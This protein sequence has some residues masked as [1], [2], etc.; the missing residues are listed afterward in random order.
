MLKALELIGF[1][2]FADK[3]RF[4]FPDGITVVVGPNGS[5]KSN[6]VDALKWV[7]GEQSAKSLRGKDMADVIFKGTGT[8]GRKPANTAEATVVFD[9]S[10]ATFPVD[11]DGSPRHPPRVSQRRRRVPDQRQALPA[12]DIRDMFRGTGV[13]VD[14]YSL[15]EQGK[16]DSCCRPTP[17]TAGRSSKKRRAS[18][19][20]RPRRSKPNAAGTRRPELLRLS[21]I[22]ERSKAGCAACGPR[23]PRPSGIASTASGCS[24]CGPL[25]ERVREIVGELEHAE[26]EHAEIAERRAEADAAVRA[27]EAELRGAGEQSRSLRDE[28]RQSVRA[29]A[30][31]AKSVRE[32]ENRLAAATISAEQ[33]GRQVDALE[34]ALAKQIERAEQS[35]REEEQK[36]EEARQAE[37]LAAAAQEAVDQTQRELAACR[38]ELSELENRRSGAR[39]RAS[40]LEE[41]EHRQEGISAGAQEVLARARQEPEGPFGDVCGLVADLIEVSAPSAPLIDVALGES[42]QYVVVKGE[43]FIEY[44]AEHRPA[45]TGRLGVLP[46]PA[47]SEATS[48]SPLDLDG[49]PGVIGRADRMIDTAPWFLPLVRRLLGTTWLVESLSHALDLRREGIVAARFVTLAGELLEPDGSLVVGPPRTAVGIVSRRSQLRELRGQM[50]A[51][52]ETF[53]SS[54]AAIGQLE[55]DLAVREVRLRESQTRHRDANAAF[56]EQ[57]ALAQSAE[58]QCEQITEQRAAA[59]AEVEQARRRRG[60]AERDLAAMQTRLADEEQRRQTLEADLHEWEIRLAEFETQR[61]DRVTAAA[62]ANVEFAKSEQR[63]ESLRLQRTQFQKDQEEREQTLDQMR[64]QRARYLEQRRDAERDVLRISSELALLYLE[65]EAAG[66]RIAEFTRRQGELHEQRRQV[67]SACQRIR[68]DIHKREERRHQVEL[69]AGEV[70]HERASLLERLQEDYG[71]EEADLERE[72]TE[73]EVRERQEIDEEIAQLR[74]KLN[75]IGAVNLDALAEVE[76]LEQRFGKLSAQ[77]QDLCNAKEALEKIIVRINADSRRL[78][79]ETLDTIR[80]NFQE[81][82]RKVFG[83][84]RA[85]IVLE[86]GADVL[87]AG[88]EIVANPPGKQSLSLSLL[89]GGERALTAVALMLAIFQF[90]PSPFCILDEVDGPLDES[91][92]GRFLDQLR[93]YLRGRSSSSSRTPRRR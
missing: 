59:A 66:R 42:A 46:L 20:S 61:R 57:R 3:T 49:R 21:D 90:R 33:S 76:E 54:Q 37:S 32:A 63:V 86:E 50:A 10:K 39:E 55:Q 65:V 38:R 51:W 7:L 52:D 23:P 36:A 18:A 6:V 78:F 79:A 58:Q 62:S 60:E 85:D 91:N 74:R 92:I 14:A 44:L 15:I 30:E 82:F 22:V 12:A 26:T 24:S 72:P 53:T 48:F 69:A 35:R 1:K 16:V 8:G 41:L 47:P 84:G 25:R 73:E 19:A 28:H 43:R 5:G 34:A 75:H 87:E 93:E 31:L 4:E 70:R 88:I 29:A 83:G 64:S 13:G 56:I 45:L 9:N 71:I 40:L 89:S 80:Q 81:V 67:A 77:H 27:C 11:A 2:S 68:A 17:R